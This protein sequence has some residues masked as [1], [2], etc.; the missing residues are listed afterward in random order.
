MPLRGEN[1]FLRG[2]EWLEAMPH[3]M[4]FHRPQNNTSVG[5][6]SRGLYYSGWGLRMGEMGH[7]LPPQLCALSLGLGCVGRLSVV[8]PL[9]FNA[10]LSVVS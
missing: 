6:Q 1:V 5:A 7:F 9:L 8:I 4:T 3:Q 10:F 2:N